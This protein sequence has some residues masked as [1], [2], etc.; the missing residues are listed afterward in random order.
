MFCM[1][2]YFFLLV[3]GVIEVLISHVCGTVFILYATSKRQRTL[4]INRTNAELVTDLL[5]L[6]LLF[7][8]DD[9]DG[10]KMIC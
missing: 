4:E 8:D 2:F 9:D 1:Y 3:K 6:W 10:D 5:L 7:V